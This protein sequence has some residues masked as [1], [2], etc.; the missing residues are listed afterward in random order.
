MPERDL[1]AQLERALAELGKQ[2]L[3]NLKLIEELPPEIRRCAAAG[4]EVAADE[5]ESLLREAR[6]VLTDTRKRIQALE[7]RLYP[8]RRRKSES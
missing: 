4:D 3:L 2:E 1:D 7:A 6:V 5:L 8:A